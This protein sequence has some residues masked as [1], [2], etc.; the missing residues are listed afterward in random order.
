MVR[1]IVARRGRPRAGSPLQPALCLCQLRRLRSVLAAKLLDGAR[2]VIAD[3]AP[4]E[5]QRASY[6]VE[7][8]ATVGGREHLPLSFSQRAH[9]LAQRR[10]GQARIDHALALRRAPNGVSELLWWGVLEQ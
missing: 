6:L 10:S 1:R 3:G 2:K 8:G 4:R 9:A 7:V 5:E